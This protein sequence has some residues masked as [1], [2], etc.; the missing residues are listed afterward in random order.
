MPLDRQLLACALVLLTAPRGPGG[1]PSPGLP[2]GHPARAQLRE[3]L[4]E[5]T[6]GAERGEG[7]AVVRGRG[8]RD[9]R[10]LNGELGDLLLP[11]D[12]PGRCGVFE[13]GEDVVCVGFR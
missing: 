5:R 11:V 8:Q 4:L 13:E 1:R 7:E 6:W 9:A 2:H 3:Q 12:V 10:L